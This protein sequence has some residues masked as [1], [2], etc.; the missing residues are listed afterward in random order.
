MWLRIGNGPV[1]QAIGI[2]GFERSNR[3]RSTSL[4]PRC[5]AGLQEKRAARLE[6]CN[7]VLLERAALEA[8][9][10]MTTCN[11][12]RYGLQNGPGLREEGLLCP[13]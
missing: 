7:P 12:G 1:V 13:R 8:N 11:P 2:G 3:S 10:V 6:L 4:Q 5:T 9:L